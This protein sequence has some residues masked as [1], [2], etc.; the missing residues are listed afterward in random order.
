VRYI[1]EGHV[2]ESP[3]NVR[4]MWTRIEE[5]LSRTMPAATAEEY[6]SPRDAEHAQ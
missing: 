5:W 6:H 2:I 3:G 1:G 4:D